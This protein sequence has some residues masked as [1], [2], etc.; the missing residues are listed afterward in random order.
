MPPA[1]A[2]V[3]GFSPRNGAVN[4]KGRFS[5]EPFGVRDIQFD[6]PRILVEPC[7]LGEEIADF[8][9]TRRIGRAGRAASDS[10]RPRSE[11]AQG[12]PHDWPRLLT[13]RSMRAAVGVALPHYCGE[14]RPPPST[15][16]RI[17][18]DLDVRG[19]AG[20]SRS[21]GVPFVGAH[22]HRGQRIAAARAAHLLERRGVARHPA[23]RRQRLQML[24]AGIG[25]RQEQEDEIDRPPVDR[26]VIDRFAQPREQ[27]VDAA[28]GP[29]SCRAGSPPPGRSRSSPSARARSGSRGP[30]PASTPS[31]CPARLASCCSNERLLPPGRA[32][33]IASKSRKSASCMVIL[34]SG[35]T[36][37]TWPLEMGNG[38]RRFAAQPNRCS[39]LRGGRS[40]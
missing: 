32:V 11:P 1:L 13:K 6:R 35:A 27:A 18:G 26:L 30:P 16:R 34:T 7:P 3:P 9:G 28:S 38:F 40:C 19:S 20:S 25:R 29:R 23:D 2:V 21:G 17:H 14:I 39:R 15:R 36:V 37:R 33:L 22:Q 24:G 4:P 8:H 5:D 12:R 31:R 10:C